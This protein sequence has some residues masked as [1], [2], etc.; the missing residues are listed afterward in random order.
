M[1]CCQNLHIK[2]NISEVK[3]GRYVSLIL[4]CL[5]FEAHLSLETVGVSS[6]HS[7]AKCVCVLV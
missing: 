3:E 5:S 7:S 4:A 2:I 6:I 1:L